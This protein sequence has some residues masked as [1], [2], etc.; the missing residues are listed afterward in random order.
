M[1]LAELA[2]HVA[3]VVGGAATI[4]VVLRYASEAVLRLA[5]GITAILAR[6]SRSRAERALD[7]LR[8]LRRDREPPDSGST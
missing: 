3:T 5:A 8:V 1:S 7:V 4:A 6:D 2:T